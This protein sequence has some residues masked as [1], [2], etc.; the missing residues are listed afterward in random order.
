MLRNHEPDCRDAWMN[1]KPERAALAA[2]GDLKR[3]PVGEVM[4]L[5]PA[6]AGV[7]YRRRMACPGCVMARFMTVAEAA[8][9]YGIRADDLA[10]DLAAA[11][12]TA[13]RPGD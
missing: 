6:T 9:V 1:V 10:R 4:D 13:K 2:P 12:W 8:S 7:F 5:W 3:L 11:A